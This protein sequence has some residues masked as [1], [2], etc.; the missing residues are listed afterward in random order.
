MFAKL[1]VQPVFQHGELERFDILVQGG[2]DQMTKW[3]KHASGM[4]S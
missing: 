2:M 1:G 3:K 4:Y